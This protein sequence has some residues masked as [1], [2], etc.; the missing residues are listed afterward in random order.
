MSSVS[1]DGME[2]TA[3]FPYQNETYTTW[4]KVVGDLPNSGHRPLV[5]LH[6]GPGMSHHYMLPHGQLHALYGIPVVFY[7]QV[8]I[9]QSTHLRDKRAGFWTMELFMDELD[10]LLAHLGIQGDFDLLGNSWGAMLAGHYAAVRHPVGMKHAVIA[11]GG[12]SMKLWETGT[13]QLLKRLQDDVREVIERGEREGRRYTEEYKAAMHVFQMK[14]ICTVDPWPQELVTSFAA[15]D[16]DPTVYGIMI[17]PSEFNVSGTLK[18]WSIVDEVQNITASTLLI[19]AYDDSAQ[20]MALMPFFLKVKQ[21]KWVQ[22]AYS[23][24]LP[25]FEEPERYFEVVGRFLTDSA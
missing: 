6:G 2:G 22:F 21:V 23:S 24:H 11:N 16:E 14:H 13:K 19:N 10:N 18:S 3:R 9:G 4:Y 5:I 25:A 7:D 15:T 1:L 8:G 12:A 17:G 20:D